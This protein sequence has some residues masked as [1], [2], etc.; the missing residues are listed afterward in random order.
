MEYSRILNTMKSQLWFLQDLSER[1]GF[2]C[3][4]QLRSACPSD[5]DAKPLIRRVH[6]K[7][8]VQLEIFQLGESKVVPVVLVHRGGLPY[9][10][11]L[12][13]STK[14]YNR[15]ADSSNFSSI[16]TDAS[17]SLAQGSISFIAISTVTPQAAK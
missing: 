5:T 13:V 10:E 11:M 7:G 14:F 3:T 16:V 6:A 1:L 4:F 2:P 17:Y 9:L 12:V 15:C 8:Y